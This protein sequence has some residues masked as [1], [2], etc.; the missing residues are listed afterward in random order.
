VGKGFYTY[1]RATFIPL[2]TDWLGRG[3]VALY[4]IR[5]FRVLQFFLHLLPGASKSQNSITYLLVI[6]ATLIL[7]SYFGS[8]TALVL[9]AFLLFWLRKSMEGFSVL[10]YVMQIVLMFLLFFI[11]FNTGLISLVFFIAV[12]TYSAFKAEHKGWYPAIL[13]AA[14]LVIVFAANFLNVD[15]AGYLKGGMSLVEGYNQ[16]MF[17]DQPFLVQ[18]IAAAA[19]I[20][21]VLV[22]FALRAYGEKQPLKNLLLLFLSGASFFVLYK[23]AFVRNDQQHVSEFYRYFLLFIVC[24][25]ELHSYPSGLSRGGLV[26]CIIIIFCLT[27]QPGSTFKFNGRLDKA[28]YLAGA[29][30]F[31]D[32]SGM[33]LSSGANLVPPGIKE[34]VGNGR[35]DAYPW[36]SHLLYENR[37]NYSPRPVC[38]AYTA[39]TPYL[40]ECNFNYYNSDSAPQFV[41]YEYESIDCRYPLFDEPKL[42]HLILN[43][44]SCVDTF[45]FDGR[46]VLALERKSPAKFTYMKL[47]EYEMAIG[48][49]LVP[50]P[51][52]FYSVRVKSSVAGKVYSLLRHAP[53]VKLTITTRDGNYHEFKTSPALLESGLFST[54]LFNSTLDFYNYLNGNR[55]DSEISAYG[56]R[57]ERPRFFDEKMVVTEYKIAN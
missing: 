29:T 54:T 11:K 32:T 6:A 1:V 8:G 47:K 2:Y 3:R 34:L 7:P 37:L 22:L 46:L 36:N 20:L 42:N 35:I 21:F 12:L 55:M 31:N 30:R 25:P 49:K 57:P 48:D 41:F 17:L 14:T 4:T 43:N 38:Q 44:Y 39:Y 19:M 5:Y 53:E 9:A 52:I 15:L 28:G 56:I 50:V 51:G 13:L 23:Q 24:V 40:E 45:R 26:S 10:A 16:V 18:N 33:L 27:P